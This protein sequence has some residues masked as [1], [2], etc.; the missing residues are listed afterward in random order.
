MPT[1]LSISIYLDLYRTRFQFTDAFEAY[2]GY[3]MNLIA[4]SLTWM[5]SRF[6]FTRTL[7][8]ISI[9][10]LFEF[11]NLPFW[12]FNLPLWNV[13]RISHIN[14]NTYKLQFEDYNSGVALFKFSKLNIEN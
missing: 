9:Y 13:I 10:L 2:I 11:F 1:L 4:G 12:N 8:E 6:Q 7:C 14:L 5:L 3:R